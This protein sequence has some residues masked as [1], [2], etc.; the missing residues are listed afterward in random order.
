[1]QNIWWSVFKRCGM[2]KNILL[3]C[4]II[5]GI[6]RY[7]NIAHRKII[8]LGRAE[9]EQGKKCIDD[10]Q[11]ID[12]EQQ[13][14]WWWGSKKSKPIMSFRSARRIRYFLSCYIFSEQHSWSQKKGPITFS[15]IFLCLWWFEWWLYGARYLRW[16]LP[17]SRG[18]GG[19]SKF[20]GNR[21]DKYVWVMVVKVNYVI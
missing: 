9:P 16:A 18:W 21:G 5:G 6:K 15:H 10:N 7:N 1:M 12:E 3:L 13:S 19:I 2:S 14:G 20:L 4:W 11:H 8:S 17:T